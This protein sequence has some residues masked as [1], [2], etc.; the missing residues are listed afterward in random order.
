MGDLLE[1]LPHHSGY[2]WHRVRSSPKLPRIDC[3]PAMGLPARPFRILSY[4]A[5]V[6]APHAPLVTAGPGP[7]PASASPARSAL[8][9]P[10]ARLWFPCM[11]LSGSTDGR[12]G[13]GGP[14]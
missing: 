7:R 3:K 11:S 4:S 8:L 13:T 1:F 9:I 6:P 12:I 2:V 10:G 14:A 5:V